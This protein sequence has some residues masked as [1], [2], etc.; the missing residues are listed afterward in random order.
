MCKETLY[1]SRV[2]N[3]NL[4][5]RIWPPN[6]WYRPW[7]FCHERN[8]SSYRTVCRHWSMKRGT[9]SYERMLVVV[10]KAMPLLI[11]Y[12]LSP[13]RFSE[14]NWHILPMAVIYW[15]TLSLTAILL[16]CGPVYK[17]IKVALNVIRVLHPDIKV[18]LYNC[19]LPWA[20]LMMITWQ[21]CSVVKIFATSYQ[22]PCDWPSF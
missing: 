20:G 3:I 6:L 1:D 4:R 17:N 16:M 21:I 9:P 7:H 18:G 19:F 15:F 13:S 14:Q 8:S 11:P 2:H 22:Q 5:D 12:Y 10:E